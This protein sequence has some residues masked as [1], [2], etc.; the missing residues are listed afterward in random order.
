MEYEIRNM[1]EL[2]HWGIKGMR[3]GVRR[4]QNKD[5]SL[6]AAGKKRISKQEDAKSA[7]EYYKKQRDETDKYYY[8]KL[9]ETGKLGKKKWQEA[10][11]KGYKGNL[12]EWFE[13]E[14]W[15]DQEMV[16]LQA[17]IDSIAYKYRNLDRKY[18]A[19]LAYAET[20]V[21]ENSDRTVD[22]IASDGIWKEGKNA[23]DNYLNTI[24]RNVPTL[25]KDPNN[26]PDYSDYDDLNHSD[27]NPDNLSEDELYHHGIKGMRWGVRRYQNKD[28]SLT[29]AGQKRR[30]KL[31][32]E[33]KK[34]HGVDE[35]G[36]GRPAAASVKP[37]GKKRISE[38]TDDEINRAIARARL[39][40]TYRAL[41]PEPQQPEKN[42]FAKKMLNEA[43]KPAVIEAG[44]NLVSSAMDGLVKKIT[45]DKVDPESLEALK[46]T[47]DKLD[48][49]NK[50]D[51]LLNPDKHLSEEDQN[52]RQQRAFDAETREAQREGYQ[53]VADKAKAKREAA[54][55]QAK[56]DAEA[57]K[58]RDEF[59]SRAASDADASSRR[60]SSWE[61]TTS[62]IRD[63]FDFDA[64]VTS[65]SKSR[66]S[67]GKSAVDDYMDY[68][69]SELLDGNGNVLLSWGDD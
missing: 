53:S 41:R 52:K 45:G 65:L 19:S 7:A 32:G 57:K 60:Q 64:P 24:N 36:S 33:L 62:N 51:K 30:A 55:R 10:V 54:E 42:A 16:D 40:D 14:M 9:D 25:K 12:E 61:K 5:G 50:I 4:Y 26:P 34:L 44:K 13:T 22:R 68:S 59:V 39:E 49:K 20:L 66:V 1:D 11:K 46:K 31:E 37:A 48:Y 2:Y 56:A 43:I 47:Y 67:R 3:W 38:M 17:K 27:I 35:N 18:D 6:T 63:E 28:G 69:Y 29:P 23:V 8:Q 58:I 21:F 15:K